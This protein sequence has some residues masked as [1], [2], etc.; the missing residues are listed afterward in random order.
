MVAVGDR[1]PD[2]PLLEVDLG[3]IH[4]SRL[5][6]TGPVVLLFIRHANSPECGAALRLYRDSLAPGLAAL[7]AHLVAVSPQAAEPLAAVKR[8]HDLD[9]FVASDGRHALIDAFNLGF[10]SPGAGPT[11]GTGR[12]VLPF[13]AVV[14]A[15]RSG[16][17]RFTD[18]RAD[19]STRTSPSRILQAVR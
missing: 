16:I 13:A 9:F 8:R 4:L 19:W 1:L 5:R 6:Q 12:S 7:D 2:L 3:A 17:V 15:D 14:V 11:L 10:S 18:V